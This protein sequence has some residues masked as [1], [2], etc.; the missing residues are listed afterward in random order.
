MQCSVYIAASLDDFIA[1]SGGA[2]RV[3]IDGGAVIQQ[4]LT[5][6]LITDLIVSFIPVLL[7]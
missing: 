4:F 6:G 1:R 3:Y 5:D 7:G 2:K